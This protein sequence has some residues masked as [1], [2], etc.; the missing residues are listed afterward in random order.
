MVIDGSSLSAYPMSRDPSVDI[1]CLR[2][3][4][5][6]VERGAG[7]AERIIIPSS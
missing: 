4:Y 1:V 3:R 7:Y 2:V 6:I 5:K